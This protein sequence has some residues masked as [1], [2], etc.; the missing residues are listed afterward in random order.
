ML[1]PSSMAAPHMQ[2]GS[3]CYAQRDFEGAHQEFTAAL[4]VQPD[5]SPAKFNLGVVSRDLEEND[6]AEKWFLEVIAAGEVL[7]DCYNN[8]GILAV[9]REELDAAVEHF[10][11]AIAER[12]EFPLAHFNLGT[13]LLRL[14]QWEEG[15]REF[16]WRWQTPT[17]TPIR[18]PQPQ[19]NG[20]RLDGTLLLHTE[21]G[22]GDTL[23]FA[24]FIPLIRERCRR[25]ILMRPEPL[26]CMFPTELWADET[27]SAG[28]IRL[29][30]FDAYLP[31]LSAPHALN[32]A[33][34][35]L[36]YRERLPD[37]STARIGSWRIAC[38]GYQIEGRHHLVRQPNPK[39]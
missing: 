28:E 37:A 8:L 32:F 30:S 15:W 13:L 2:T 39:Q 14:A 16:E 19:W 31:L 18:C 12:H 1:E 23:Q 27:R 33:M 22:I 24:R 29:D 11:R 20:D 35:E 21:Q 38:T 36:P 4:A 34:D 3:A 5:L 6:A 10:R 26:G 17:F 9:R 25:V 7:A